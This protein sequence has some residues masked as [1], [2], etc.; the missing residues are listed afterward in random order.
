M[1]DLEVHFLIDRL[2]HIKNS[3]FALH[4]Y[5]MASRGTVKLLSQGMGRSPE[6]LLPKAA[7]ENDFILNL[8]LLWGLCF[9]VKGIQFHLAFN[10]FSVWEFYTQY[11][12]P[13][14]KHL[15]QAQHHSGW[16]LLVPP[17]DDFQLSLRILQTHV[18]ET[19]TVPSA[20]TQN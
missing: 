9:K 18:V 16:M 5:S 4:T 3:D 17:A 12:Y 14:A 8:F 20:C 1:W 2:S 10:R 6:N 15:V 11:Y 19:V 13:N 7:Y